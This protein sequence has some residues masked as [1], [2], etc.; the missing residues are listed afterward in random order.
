VNSSSRTTA[1][2][3]HIPADEPRALTVECPSW[4][5]D[6]DSPN[7]R[8][9]RDLCE[10]AADR[11]ISPHTG[12]AWGAFTAGGEIDVATGGLEVSVE[13]DDVALAGY[14]VLGGT[15]DPAR[16]RAFAADALAAATWLETHR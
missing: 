6:A 2:R 11:L 12:G 14:G 10:I 13:V 3:G 5:T 7:H 1:R 16:L 15:T 4:C 9:G 8:A